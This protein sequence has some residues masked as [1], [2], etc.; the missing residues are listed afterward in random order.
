MSQI[1][2]VALKND[3][4]SQT[5]LQTALCHSVWG[6][7]NA[8][9]HTDIKKGDQ[10]IFL[11]GISIENIE[12]MRAV[13][14][15]ND[16][17]NVFPNYKN[18]VITP[19]FVECFKFR[20]DEILYGTIESD[21]FKQETEVWEPRINEKTGKKNYYINRF[22][23]CLTHKSQNV[24]LNASLA[25]IDFH[26][27]VI[28]A[29][30][31]KRVEPCEISQNSLL[32]IE[33]LLNPISTLLTDEESYQESTSVS[34][35]IHLP[36]GGIPVEPNVIVSKSNRWKRNP[37][38]AKAAIE[39][40]NFSCEVDPTHYTFISRKTNE[41]FVEAHHLIPMEAQGK[42][43]FSLD[44]PENIFALCPNCHRRFHHASSEELKHL[45]A[46]TYFK[47]ADKLKERDIYINL[48]DLQ[49]LYIET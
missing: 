1:W 23:W 33:E 39:V 14:T 43:K 34:F 18:D 49:S 45:I 48:E 42:F 10:V 32:N 4:R 2:T 35:P 28:K 8:G 6:M 38:I 25:N 9:I 12:N 41:N 16:K 13:S 21:F 46:Q 5:N 27:N 26:T 40:A 29:L 3:E 44:V 24:L 19:D 31:S 47:R 17:K 36:K 22:K 37:S 30:R 11:V 15:F 7:K 20:V